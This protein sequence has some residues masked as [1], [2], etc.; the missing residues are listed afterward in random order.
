MKYVYGSF[1]ILGTLFPLGAFFPWIIENGFNIALLF[2]DATHNPISTF[3]WAD[4]IIS[5]LEP[6]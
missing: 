1:C 6:V 3:A 4:V 5:G 2:N